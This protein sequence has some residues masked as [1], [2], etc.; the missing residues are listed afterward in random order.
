MAETGSFGDIVFQASADTVKTWDKLRRSRKASYAAHEVAEGKARLEFTGI[1]LQD[2]D[3]EVRLDARF[4]NPAREA[5]ALLDVQAAGEPRPLILGGTP[6]GKYVLQDV[7]E[8][9]ERTDG[10]GRTLTSRVK[11]RFREYN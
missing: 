1:D 5:E 11:L 6:L 4:A 9:V 10:K 2:V 3:L 8:R 7:T